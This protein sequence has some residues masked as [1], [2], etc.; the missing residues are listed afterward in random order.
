MDTNTN[1]NDKLAPLFN[2]SPALRAHLE[3][4]IRI[5]TMPLL[6]LLTMQLKQTLKILIYS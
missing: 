3:A 2:P 1:Q 6:K 4:V 5:Q